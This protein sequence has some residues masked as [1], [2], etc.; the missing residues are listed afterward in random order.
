[1]AELCAYLDL[2]PP[3][4]F[5]GVLLP[6]VLGLQQPC[7]AIA[8]PRVRTPVSAEAPSLCSLKLGAGLLFVFR[9]AMA[10]VH[11][12]VLG[13]ASPSF[14]GSAPFVPMRGGRVSP[15]KLEDGVSVSAGAHGDY[16]RASPPAA[17]FRQGS[18][19]VAMWGLFLLEGSI[20]SKL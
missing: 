17:S 8:S 16:G 3:M 4:C 14:D 10:P 11:S 13:G 12:L 1:M 9:M 20:I 19:G 15:L 6:T 7:R 5:V 2:V 18:A